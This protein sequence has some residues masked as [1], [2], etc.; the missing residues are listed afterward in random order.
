MAPFRSEFVSRVVRLGAL[1]PSVPTS[2]I[3]T[4]HLRYPSGIRRI[5]D[6]VGF[7]DNRRV[8][9]DLLGPLEVGDGVV[10]EPRDRIALSVLLVQ[11]NQLVTSEQLADALWADRPPSSW[12]KQVQI[13]ISRLRKAL[14]HDTIATLA[15]GYRLVIDESHLDSWQFE[16][17]ITRGHELMAGGEPDRAVVSYARALALWRGHPLE[18]LDGWA[19]GQI[20]VVRLEELRLSTQEDWLDARLAAGDHRQVAIDALALAAESPLRERRWRLLALAQYRSARQADALRSLATARR[21]LRDELG[22]E[23]GADL[24]ALEAAILRQ[25]SELDVRVV[26]PLVSAACP[27][28]GL[29]PYDVVDHDQFFGRDAE[30]SLALDRLRTSP[31]LVLAGPSGSGKSSLARAGLAPMLAASGRH[32]VTMFPGRDPERALSEAITPDI[33]ESVVIVDQFEEMFALGVPTPE[34]RAFCARLARYATETA[35]VILVVRSDHLGDLA[36]APELSRLAEQGLHLVTPLAGA[37][38]REAIEQPAQRAGLRVERG[39]V[40]LLE[41]DTEGEPGALPLLSHALA[42]T[43]LRRDGPVL[44][45]EGYQATG[46]IRG[47]VANSA[48][49]LYDSLSIGERSVL[50]S[51]LLRMVSPSIDGPPMRCRVPRRN[52]TGDPDRDRVVA[53]LVRSR[54][55]TAE[56]D[57]YELA[58][59]ALARAW[60]RLQAWLDDDVDGQRV[61]RHLAARSEEWESSGRLPAELYRG[62]RLDGALEWRDETHPDLN[63]VEDEFLA[64][65]VAARTSEAHDLAA[66]ARR[67]SRQNRRLRVLV[68]LVAV[69]FVAASVTVVAARNARSDARLEALV[70]QSLALRGGDRGLA[71]LLAVEAHRRQ[72]DAR[73]WSALLGTFTAAPGFL[74]YRYVPGVGRLSGALVPGTSEAVIAL[75]GGALRIVNL[76]SGDIDDRFTGS[77]PVTGGSRLAVSGDGRIVAQLAGRS[78]GTS[79]GGPGSRIQTDG[80]G[81]AVLQVYETRTGRQVMEPVIS[82]FGI[83]QV[84]INADGSSVA[85]TGGYDGDVAIYRPDDSEP[86]AVIAGLARPDDVDMPW[87]VAGADFGSDG[88]L[89]IGSLAGP[90]RVVDPTSGVVLDT[91]DAPRLS[92]N[93]HLVAAPDGRVVGAGTEGVVAFAADG[94]LLWSVDLR[95]AAT[96]EPCPW[97]AVD[98]PR[99]VFHCGN[100]FGVIEEYSLRT[101]ELTGTSFDPQLGD[102]GPMDVSA[103]GNELVVFGAASPTI[104]RWRFD[105]GGLVTDAVAA[106]HVV[107]DGYDPTGDSILVSR[108]HP[109]ASTWDEFT[110]FATWNPVD[111]TEIARADRPLEGMGWVGAATLSAYSKAE[112]RIVFADAASMEP[113]DGLDVPTEAINLFVSAGGKR[114]YVTFGGGEVWTVDP[115][116]RQRV[117]PTFSITGSPMTVSATR[118]AERVV[119]TTFQN[120]ESVT[121]VYDGRTGRRLD[122]R[123][124]GP[125]RTSVSLDGTLVGATGGKIIEYDLDTLEPIGTFPG[126]RGEVNTLEF[127]ADGHTLLAAANDQTVSLF[128]VASRRRIG[129][130]IAAFSPLIGAGH[131]HPDGTHVAVN[132][133]DGVVIWDIDPDHLAAAACRL[134]GRNLTETEWNTYLDGFGSYRPTCPEYP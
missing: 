94:S 65:S 50:R 91:W 81:C 52:M 95:T 123:L 71:A 60:P 1:T 30:V 24:V 83:G 113:L 4:G 77:E 75:D 89:Y 39:L 103:D 63:P 46:G 51:L 45:I 32:V 87:E 82:P 53:L 16:Q 101:G 109:T 41:R 85:V 129:D 43:W 48:D 2:G 131:L 57:S 13:C 122:G 70:N 86:V 114:D 115:G 100:F 104:A 78:G 11:R 121:H 80:A 37:E 27:Y 14:G 34:V 8:K 107:Y 25:D 36:M 108:R 72:P 67:T 124:V 12:A 49:R 20:E 21:I 68:V 74:G 127:S 3:E 102:V 42:E 128:D 6:E 7:S 38:L 96:P 5:D 111:D 132:E 133:R 106:G 55:V 118:N 79:C 92:S 64:A 97:F 117:E 23:P 69:L 47:A 134:A 10:L 19:A 18:E 120:P 90:I 22:I 76:D 26:A 15:N 119:I 126:A 116:T 44:T 112:D 62:A 59:E 54:L 40:E 99:D 61:M 31:L 33:S 110:E 125:F 17:L 130:P 28:K 98:T 73:S 66:A 93:N 58:H 56:E 9:V 29:T 35:P 84:A 105:G 88:R